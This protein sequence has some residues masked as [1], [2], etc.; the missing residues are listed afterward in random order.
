MGEICNT[1]GRINHLE[2]FPMWLAGAGAKKGLIHAGI[3]LA[4]ESVWRSA[5]RELTPQADLTTL[6]HKRLRR[7]FPIGPGL[8]PAPRPPRIL[9]GDDMALKQSTATICWIMRCSMTTLSVHWRLTALLG[10]LVLTVGFP[11]GS[12]AGVADRGGRSGS[13][14]SANNPGG[15][16]SLV[17]EIRGAS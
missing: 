4:T 7:L 6:T 12:L 1:I 3:R 9:H 8:E 17:L 15:S 5:T 10:A 16:R 14:S 11:R 2:A 13:S